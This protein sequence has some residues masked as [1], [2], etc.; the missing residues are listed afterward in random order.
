MMSKKVGSKSFLQVATDARELAEDN[1]VADA[2]V[3]PMYT[4]E[5]QPPTPLCGCTGNI[6]RVLIILKR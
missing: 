4:L 5:L 1:E 3:T 6:L 2:A